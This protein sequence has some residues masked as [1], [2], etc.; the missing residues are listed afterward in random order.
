[1][2][3]TA[4]PADPADPK[5][6]ASLPA[7]VTRDELAHVFRVHPKTIYHWCKARRFPPPLPSSGRRLRWVKS[8]VLAWAGMGDITHAS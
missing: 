1:L 8:Q 5:A 2:A 3:K 6:I 4:P 7:I